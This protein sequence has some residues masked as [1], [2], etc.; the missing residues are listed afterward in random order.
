MDGFEYL[1]CK[2]LGV[3]NAL[4]YG[5]GAAHG[6]AA[7]VYAVQ[8]CLEV[9]GAAGV[10]RDAI[11]CEKLSVHLLAHGRDHRVAVDFYG[12]AGFHR[13]A[14]SGGIR[15]SQLHPLAQQGS[16]LL[17][18]RGHQLQEPNAV[19]NGQFQLLRV[20]GHVFLCP[21]IDQ[22]GGFSSRPQ[23]RAGRIH[24]GV[25]AAH[26]GH[27]AQRHVFSGLQVPQ[28]ADDRDHVATD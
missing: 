13:G 27:M 7:A 18:H 25:A 14:P 4:Y 2:A 23:G 24:G 3:G 26:H 6:V 10:H 1:V 28:P 5:G 19:G 21:A 15:L 8:I 11:I 16:V 22:G 12:F 20:C 9:G 17:L